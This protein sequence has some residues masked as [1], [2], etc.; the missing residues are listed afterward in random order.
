MESLYHLGIKPSGVPLIF[1]KEGKLFKENLTTMRTVIS[2]FFKVQDCFE[3]EQRKIF[4]GLG[5]IGMYPFSFMTAIRA[6]LHL[7]LSF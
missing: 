2:S 7:K 1:G 6:N 3:T 4:N 5:P